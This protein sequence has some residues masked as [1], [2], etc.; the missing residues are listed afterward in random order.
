MYDKT[1][2]ARLSE[3]AD[4]LREITGS[5]EYLE[6]RAK[7]QRQRMLGS[8]TL[9]KLAGSPIESTARRMADT[10][11][12]DNYGYDNDESRELTLVSI[13]PSFINSQR[14]LDM[15]RNEMSDREYDI[16]LEPVDE[17]NHLVGEMIDAGQF[18]KKSEAVGFIK[19][20]VLRVR[21]STEVIN[22]ASG[23]MH[24]V[25]TGVCNEIASESVIRDIPGVF[26]VERAISRKDES[27]GRDLVVL[28]Y[29]GVDEIPI[30]IKSSRF[31]VRKSRESVSCTRDGGIVM[32]SGFSPEDFGDNLIPDADTLKKKIPYYTDML[33]DAVEILTNEN[34]WNRF[35]NFG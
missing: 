13:L 3:P 5:T 12:K 11:R 34:K 20:I 33:D 25:L 7:L 35:A 14:K 8:T 15:R 26:D 10:I 29:K 23:I 2:N 16:I 1:K 4:V 17:F 24:D 21:A 6:E 27:K 31:G 32:Q 28:G 22:Y 9:S 19:D 30:D 18:T